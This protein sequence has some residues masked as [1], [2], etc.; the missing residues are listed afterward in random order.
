MKEICVHVRKQ[1]NH[2]RVNPFRFKYRIKGCSRK[3]KDLTIKNMKAFL[4]VRFSF[5]ESITKKEANQILKRWSHIK[6]LDN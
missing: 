1:K 3:D 2:L 4:K 6:V 5:T